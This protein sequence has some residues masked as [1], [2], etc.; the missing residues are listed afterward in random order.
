MRHLLAIALTSLALAACG[1]ANEPSDAERPTSTEQAATTRCR[2]GYYYSCNEKDVCSCVAGTAPPPPCKLESTTG[3][4]GYDTWV[5][6]WATYPPSGQCTDIPGN[7][8]TWKQLSSE[9]AGTRAPPF[10]FDGVPNESMNGIFS[11]QDCSK[12]LGPGCCTYVWWPDGFVPPTGKYTAT[13]GA[14]QDMQALCFGPGLTYIALETS[15][16]VEDNEAGVPCALP[17]GGSCGTCSA[18]R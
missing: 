18:I 14:P 16:C 4:P 13:S 5:E 11:V 3:Q 15:V 6:S 17:G 9:Y 2:A 10:A 7:Q 12:V 1:T 8:G